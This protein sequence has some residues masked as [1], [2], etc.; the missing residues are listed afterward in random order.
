[1][2]DLTDKKKWLISFSLVYNSGLYINV[3][4]PTEFSKLIYTVLSY[5]Y[6]IYLLATFDVQNGSLEVKKN[7][8]NVCFT[9]YFVNGSEVQGC[10]VKYKCLNTDFSGNITIMRASE[11]NNTKAFM[12][13]TGIHSSTY[14][15][16]FYDVD[17]NN[18]TYENDYAVI[19]TYQTVNDISSLHM[20]SM[21]SVP[22]SVYITSSSVPT[23]SLTTP[24]TDCDSS[25]LLYYCHCICSFITIGGT[26]QDH[27][28][29]IIPGCEF[30]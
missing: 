27:L 19:L 28:L 12:Y 23:L 24:C 14:N 20:T 4:Q 10:F 16:T 3:S 11:H 18:I 26:N 25:K 29:I 17:H 8:R 2:G 22:S 21:S 13:V 5:V 30:I 15:V 1:M 6:E 7:A 9:C